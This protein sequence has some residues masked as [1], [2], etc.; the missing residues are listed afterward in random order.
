MFQARKRHTSLHRFLKLVCLQECKLS[1]KIPE[2][3]SLLDPTCPK[4]QSKF[5]FKSATISD[6]LS[7]RPL[8]DSLTALRSWRS[9][10]P[11]ADLSALERR[12]VLPPQTSFWVGTASAANRNYV[13]HQ[14]DDYLNSYPSGFTRGAMNQSSWSTN[15]LIIGWFSY[16]VTS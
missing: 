16:S 7:T 2:Q 8:T 15:C 1:L 3:G 6:V 9:E 13:S 11:R 10:N 5:L 4:N 14:N 12:P